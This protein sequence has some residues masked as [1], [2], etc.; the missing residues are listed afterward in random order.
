MLAVL[1]PYT[2]GQSSGGVTVLP[3]NFGPNTGN[4]PLA[5]SFCSAIYGLAAVGSNVPVTLI[6]ESDGG[7]N[8]SQFVTSPLGLQCAGLPT[9]G[10][11]T[12][13]PSPQN[14]LGVDW[15]FSP[16]TGAPVVTTYCGPGAGNDNCPSTPTPATC[17][18]PNE[19]ATES[20]VM[21]DYVSWE[22][23]VAR[24]ATH[25]TTSDFQYPDDIE[26][27]A[28]TAAGSP[29]GYPVLS[30]MT[31]LV[32][33]LTNFV[34]APDAGTD[35][36]PAVQVRRAEASGTFALANTVAASGVAGPMGRHASARGWGFSGHSR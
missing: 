16:P 26:C 27:P 5:A 6:F 19:P 7:E 29:N 8:D 20:Q 10:G 12:A 36:V 22:Q 15:G 25:W 21:S 35:A 3:A 32:D 33:V 4:T 34:P 31:W 14:P 23:K 9:N 24:Y 17:I 11:P 2:N 18:E 30:T 28:A 13:V 1:S